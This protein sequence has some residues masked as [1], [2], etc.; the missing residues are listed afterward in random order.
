MLKNNLKKVLN[1]FR[2]KRFEKYKLRNND[3]TILCN[4]CIGG[5]MYHDLK[6]KFLSPTINLYFEHHG[7]IDFILHLEDYIKNGKLF[8]CKEKEKSNNAPIGIL[9]C[10]N[11]PDIKIHFLHYNSFSEAYLKWEER[12]LRINWN[13]I[14]LVIEARDIH[15]HLL[16][17]EYV[18]LPY[19]KVIFTDEYIDHESVIHM[20]FYDK[21][22]FKKPI[23]SFISLSGKK[24][25][26]S[27]NFVEQ[28]FNG[29][30]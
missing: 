14:F 2:L 28:I 22:D 3:V 29:D 30:Y 9:K 8:E 23:T 12:C 20:P 13:K 27:Y 16:I 11:L 6:L 18:N 21:H 5:C 1:F 24:G 25:Y 19:K 10:K 7:F 15:E 26:D 4:C 17:S